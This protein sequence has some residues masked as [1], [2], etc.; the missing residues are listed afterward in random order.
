MKPIEVVLHIFLQVCDA[1]ACTRRQLVLHRD[2]KPNN[3]S[4]AA[5]I[6]M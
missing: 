5:A 2:I 1:L 6:P 3:T 4:C